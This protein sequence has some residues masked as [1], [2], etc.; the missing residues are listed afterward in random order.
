MLGR[1]IPSPPAA[2]PVELRGR[3]FRGSDAR[4]AGAISRAGLSGRRV[5]RLFRDV[6]CDPGITVDHQLRCRA[7]ALVLPGRVAFAGWSA[8]CLLGVAGVDAAADV[9]VSA[10]HGSRWGPVAG[11]RILARRSPVAMTVTAGLRVETREEVLFTLA[12]R[13]VPPADAVVLVDAALG[14]WPVLGRDL[15]GLVR[16]WSGRPGLC[17]ARA[18]LSVA[19]GGAESPMESR[20][21][22]W[23]I[24]AGLPRPQ[25]QHTVRD[26]RGGFVARVD[27]AWPAERVAV[28]YDGADHVADTRRMRADRARL[29]ALLA[30]GWLVV[31]ATS[32]VLRSGPGSLAGQVRAVLASRA[33]PVTTDRHRRVRLRSTSGCWTPA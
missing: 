24:D 32:D 4:A 28:E 2:L 9:V 15:D 30:A 11:V 16:S 12:S 14:R 13:R 27:L 25:V 1:V 31:H 18:V 17:R 10:P 6:Y 33:G 20:L 7:L 3:I 19:D 29:N 26:Q 21:R 23:L 22:V 8:A 5:R